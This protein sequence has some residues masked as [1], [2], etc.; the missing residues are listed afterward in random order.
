MKNHLTFDL[1]E[2]EEATAMA[3]I[4]LSFTEKGLTFRVWNV[5]V[6][7]HVELTGGF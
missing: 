1:T 2:T 7:A 3:T 6:T 4:I 5:G